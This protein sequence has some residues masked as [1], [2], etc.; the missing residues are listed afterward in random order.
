[1]PGAPV[2]PNGLQEPYGAQC[3]LEAA[4]G[5]VRLAIGI[6]LEGVEIFRRICNGISRL[7]RIA[8]QRVQIRIRNAAVLGQKRP[9]IGLIAEHELDVPV[10]QPAICQKGEK[11][12]FVQKGGFSAAGVVQVLFF[13][14]CAAVT[15]EQGRPHIQGQ[16]EYLQMILLFHHK[17]TPIRIGLE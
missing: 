12:L 2:G 8:G 7:D 11:F 15:D 16:V 17:V 3:T 6:P 1:M 10:D 4:A 9:E 5:N 13:S 14:I